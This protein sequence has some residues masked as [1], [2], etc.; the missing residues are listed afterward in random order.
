MNPLKNS[1]LGALGCGARTL[2]GLALMIAAAEAGAGVLPEPT[3]LPKLLQSGVTL[4]DLNSATESEVVYRVI[5]PEGASRLEVSTSGGVGDCDLFVRRGAHPTEADFDA[6]SVRFGNADRVTIDAPEGGAWF[7]LLHA[8]DPYRAVRLLA[9]VTLPRRVLATPR[10]TPGPGTVTAGALVTLR[11]PVRGAIVHFTLDGSEPTPAAERYRTPLA[12]TATTTVKAR[13]F[14]ADGSA[15]P[16]A[17]G[18]FTIEPEGTVTTLQSGVPALHRSGHRGL[19]IF[20]INVPAGQARTLHVETSGGAGSSALYLR[21]GAPPTL[22]EYDRRINGRRNI[23]IF[24]RKEATPGDWFIGVYGL[25][26]YSDV[27]VLAHHNVPIPDLIAWP[28]A[29]EPYVTHETFDASDCAVVEGHITA[30]AHRLLRFTTESRNIGGADVVMG[31][32]VGNPAFEFQDCHGHYHFLGF[33]RYRLLDSAGQP[34]ALGRKVSFCLED[35]LQW[36]PSA[37]PAPKY[38]CDAQGIQ[39]GWSDVY[40]SGLEGQWIDITG[41]PAGNYTLEVTMNPDRVLL[42]ADYTNNTATVPVVIP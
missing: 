4:R 11:S 21:H 17:D 28:D 25:G 8:A 35:V 30:G 27:A 18:L 12:L 34:A 33:A 14:L 20:K 42:E 31:S 36:N 2:A 15:S 1:A 32:P 38:D 19:S 16:V 3:E 29:L 7:V 24:D 10:F 5:V 13:A 40:D 22:R 37:A 41:V 26:A 23:A 39:A 9:R 6:A